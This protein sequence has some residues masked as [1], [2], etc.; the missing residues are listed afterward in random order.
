MSKENNVLSTAAGELVETSS[1]RVA[2]I[3]ELLD[4]II[5]FVQHEDTKTHTSRRN[6]TI[7]NLRLVSRLFHRLASARFLLVVDTTYCASA[8][9]YYVGPSKG[10]ITGLVE[11]CGKYIHEINLDTHDE[12]V[13]ELIGECCLNVQKVTLTFEEMPGCSRLQADY[14][15]VL[16]TWASHPN[17]PLRAVEAVM[18]LEDVLGHAYFQDFDSVRRYFKQ[19]RKLCFRCYNPTEHHTVSIRDRCRVPIK[20][21]RFLD[22]LLYFPY[23]EAL[24]FTGFFIGWE[25]MPSRILDAATG[26]PLAFRNLVTLDLDLQATTLSEICRLNNMLPCLDKL[27]IDQIHSANLPFEGWNSEDGWID[28]EE[29]GNGFGLTDEDHEQEGIDSSQG[30]KDGDDEKDEENGGA[31]DVD[32]G[33]TRSR[34]TL[35]SRVIYDTSTENEGSSQLTQ[36][37]ITKFRVKEAHVADLAELCGLAPKLREL[38]CLSTVALGDPMK[39]HS[40]RTASLSPLNDRSWQFLQLVPFGT[41]QGKELESFLL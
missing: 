34:S 24:S 36:L 1:F 10:E 33:A 7:K 38:T 35:E 28:D 22:T 26:Q 5:G 18:A 17:H 13:L 15:E 2:Q 12:E 30:S 6:C 32:A 27:Y 41:W 23:L 37:T 29:G 39:V 21:G 40:D 3:P 19:I 4:M 8:Y 14:R 25:G 9:D 16:S 31:A 20:W 11:H